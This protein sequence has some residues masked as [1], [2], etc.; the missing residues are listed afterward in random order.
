MSRSLTQAMER[1]LEHIS[2]IS[3]SLTYRGIK[4]NQQTA[5]AEKQ[6]VQLTYRGNSYKS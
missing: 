1:G 4:Y 3:M 2:E 6:H 5:V